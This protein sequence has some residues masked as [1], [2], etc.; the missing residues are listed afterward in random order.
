MSQ[1]KNTG[2]QILLFEDEPM[3]LTRTCRE[4]HE[5][6]YRNVLATDSTAIAARCIAEGELH[7]AILDIHTDEEET[8]GITLAERCAEAD[9]QVVFTTGREDLLKKLVTLSPSAVLF[10]PYTPATLLAAIELAFAGRY[11]SEVKV[12]TFTKKSNLRTDASFYVRHKQSHIRVF[13]SDVLII[14]ADKSVVHIY[15]LHDRYTLSTTLVSL[16]RQLQND[17]LVRVDRSNIINIMNIERFDSGCVFF[18]KNQYLDKVSISNT[19]LLEIKSRLTI[20]K[21]K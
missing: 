8:A 1:S 2:F 16:S 7:L 17:M 14:R 6:G 5:A 13:Y 4:L 9:V 18:P 12:D 15:T 3:V 21:A 19:T 20:L 10:K 11:S